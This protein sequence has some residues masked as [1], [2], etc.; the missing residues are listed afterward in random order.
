MMAK[1]NGGYEE[2][3]T[4]TVVSQVFPLLSGWANRF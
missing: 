4:H 2:K 3:S 1:Q